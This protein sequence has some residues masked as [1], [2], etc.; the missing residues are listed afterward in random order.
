MPHVRILRHYIHTSVLIMSALEGL[1]VGLAAYLGHYTAFPEFPD[2]WTHLPAASAF[3]IAI[4]LSMNAMNVYE[5]RI[6]EGFPAMM[7]RTAVSMF[8]LGTM[9]NAILAFHHV[10]TPDLRPG[11]SLCLEIRPRT[12]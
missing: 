6:R 8:L 5:A 9:A 1:L 2:F 7:L 11:S 10:D 3:S 4:V 12:S